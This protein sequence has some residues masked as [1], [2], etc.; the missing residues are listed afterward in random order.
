MTAAIL[1]AIAALAAQDTAIDADRPHV[2]TGTHVVAPDDV[3]VELG[4]QWQGSLEAQTFGSPALVRIGVADR[5]EIR[6]SCDGLLMRHDTTTDAYGLG[7]VQLGAKVRLWG[8]RAEP[9]VSVMPTINFGV[10]SREKRFGNGATDATLTWLAGREIAG[11]VHLEGN[12]GIGLI[13]DDRE[14]HFTQHLITGAIVLQ[15][16]KTLQTY[17]EAAW[18]SRQERG[19]SAVSFIDYGIIV[20]IRPRLLL[21]GGAF[22]GVT[23]STPDWGVFSGVSFAFSRRDFH[24]ELGRGP[25][26]DGQR[27]ILSTQHHRVGS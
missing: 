8:D 4:V 22:S 10:A 27:A 23:A 18:W 20:A 13:G 7:N 16:T 5:F 15:T 21:D 17:V 2:G 26:A 6:V 24:K 19:G 25:R 9:V 12:Y 1:L 3:Q 14:S 11:R